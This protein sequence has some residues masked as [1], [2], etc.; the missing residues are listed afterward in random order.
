ML[1]RIAFFV[2]EGCFRFT[3][4]RFKNIKKTRQLAKEE[5][6]NQLIDSITISNVIQIEKLNEKAI[7]VETPEDAAAIIKEYEEIIR[8]KRK[9]IISV[10][11]H[12]RNV[13]SRYREKEKFMKLVSDFKLHKDTI[14]F[15]LKYF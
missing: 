14:I 4:Q 5:I 13:F 7:K 11:Y 9:G 10:T 12:Q 15:R 8:T 2:C 1:N 6:K 3:L